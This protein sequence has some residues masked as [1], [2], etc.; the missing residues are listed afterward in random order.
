[1]AAAIQA[2]STWAPVRTDPAGFARLRVEPGYFLT[3]LTLETVYI[4]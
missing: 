4:K 2:L 1:M 3:H